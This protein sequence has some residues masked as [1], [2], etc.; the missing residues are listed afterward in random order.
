MKTIY[1]N[2]MIDI[3]LLSNSPVIVDA[4][5]ALGNCTEWILKNVPNCKIFCIEPCKSH[6]EKLKKYPV[7]VIEAALMGKKKQKSTTFHEFKGLPRW[8]N[9][10]GINLNVRHKKL[11]GIES[12]T[13]DLINLEQLVKQTGFIDYMK[14]D[15][16]GSEEEVINDMNFPIT[17][18]IS[19]EWHQNVNVEMIRKKMISLGYSL[20]ENV[21]KHEIY[22]V[23]T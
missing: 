10:T 8:G 9:T 19:L 6:A 23:M 15:I 4:G 5:A 1:G 22:G 21:S 2:H 20:K 16:E 3:S 14:M 17:K 12:Y 13:V 7:V 18:Q 11:K